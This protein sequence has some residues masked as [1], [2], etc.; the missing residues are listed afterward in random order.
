MNPRQSDPYFNYSN[1]RNIFDRMRAY[2]FLLSEEA[3]D[4][5]YVLFR[6]DLV[7]DFGEQKVFNSEQEILASDGDI[8]YGD[9]SLKALII[10]FYANPQDPEEV[11]KQRM[12]QK[13]EREILRQLE[14][15]RK[16]ILNNDYPR[17]YYDTEEDFKS[18]NLASWIA[19]KLSEPLIS[20]ME[21][22]E[23]SNIEDLSSIDLSQ[24]T[25]IVSEHPSNYASEESSQYSQFTTGFTFTNSFNVPNKQKPQDTPV[26]TSTFGK[27]GKYG[28]M[29]MEGDF[30]TQIPMSET[31]VDGNMS[32]KRYVSRKGNKMS[33]E[34]EMSVEETLQPSRSI[35]TTVISSG[36]TDNQNVLDMMAASLQQQQALLNSSKKPAATVTSKT[37][38]L[39]SSKSVKPEDEKKP[40]RLTKDTK[41]TKENKSDKV[42]PPTIIST[43]PETQSVYND[44]ESLET[45]NSGYSS[46]DI[47]DISEDGRSFTGFTRIKRSG[48]LSSNTSSNLN[49]IRE[50]KQYVYWS[51]SSIPKKIEDL[52][53]DQEYLI[54][55]DGIHIKK[56]NMLKIQQVLFRIN[57]LANGRVEESKVDKEM[58]LLGPVGRELLKLARSN[59][60]FREYLITTFKF[61]KIDATHA[62]AI[63]RLELKELSKMY[64][65]LF[66]GTNPKL[67]LLISNAD[68]SLTKDIF[69]WALFCLIFN[70]RDLNFDKLSK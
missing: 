2:V 44:D 37:S 62:Y 33:T 65:R 14:I 48:I 8:T 27:G 55:V 11:Y 9:Y 17:P 1:G 20:S 31:S 59:E 49:T 64:N 50:K 30:D 24:A 5:P 53:V 39:N 7:Y 60:Y 69:G 28:D 46:Y 32:G 52:E 70:G 68:Y 40:H 41:I 67:F 35:P 13:E 66:L 19:E 57:N 15:E 16:I 61:P 4:V 63:G 54:D 45:G 12:A 56:E 58:S 47:S 26:F 3:V 6:K 36:N 29:S 34:G 22:D 42:N 18:R 25:T 23:I 38:K 10:D 51:L 43:Q 21:T